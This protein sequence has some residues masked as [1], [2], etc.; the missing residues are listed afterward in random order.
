MFDS[1][2]HLDLS[3]FDS[4]RAEVL[5]RAQGADLSGLLVP[6][7]RP[8]TFAQVEALRTEAD[9]PLPIVIAIGVHPQVADQLSADEL[10]FATDPDAIAAAA[11][12]ARAVAIGECGLDG[13][14]PAPERQEEILRA[15]IRAARATGLPLVLHVLRAHQAAPRLF[16]EE[17]L[18]EVGGV[19]HSYSGGADLVRVYQD[20]GLC[21]SVA[22]PVTFPGSRR[23]WQAARTIPA[24]LL[25]AETDSPDQTPHPH[26]GKRNEPAFLREVIAALAQARGVPFEEMAVV[27]SRN[28]RRLFRLPEPPRQAF[29]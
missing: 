3:A 12:K 23:P 25:L 26:R 22:G 5:R 1:H 9:A 24:D 18:S 20:L 17:R 21:F 10:A 6:G 29:S 19:M 14:T 11:E 7:V 8:S 4:D 27:T 2:C 13:G 16:R 15:H 28:A